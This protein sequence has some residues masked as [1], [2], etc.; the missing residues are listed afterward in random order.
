MRFCEL[1]KRLY[2]SK[3]WAASSQKVRPT[4]VKASRELP[5]IELAF[6]PSHVWKREMRRFRG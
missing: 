2:C 4:I 3:C 1:R 6:P 5:T